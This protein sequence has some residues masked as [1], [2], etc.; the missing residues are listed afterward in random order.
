MDPR[1]ENRKIYPRFTT[2]IQLLE[3]T[4]KISFP[5][6]IMKNQLKFLHW[7]LNCVTRSISVEQ[8]S[9]L[10]E[11]FHLDYTDINNQDI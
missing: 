5:L 10:G 2:S 11:D 7:I 1:S 3:K 4:Q 8:P 9:V 6:E